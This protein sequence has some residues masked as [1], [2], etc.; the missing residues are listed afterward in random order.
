[1]KKSGWEILQGKENEV[2]QYARGY[3]DYISLNKT[4]R[5]VVQYVRENIKGNKD[6][7]ELENHGKSVALFKEGKRDIKDGLR[8]VAAHIDAPRI[9]M[10]P[11]A[12]FEDRESKTALF[13]T[14]YYGGIKKYQWV[15]RPLAIVGLVVKEDGTHIDVS[16]G[17]SE[18]DPVFTFADLLP[19]LS[20]KVQYDKKLYD[21]I[22]AEKLDL[23]VGSYHIKADDNNKE[24]VKAHIIELLKK[25]YSIEEEDFVSA[26]LEIVPAGRAREVG[27]DRSMIGAYGH[28]DRICGYTGFTAF[29]D[30]AN[31]TWPILLLL[32]DKEEIGSNGNTGARSKFVEYAVLQILEKKGLNTDALS[33]RRILYNSE[34]MSADVSAGVNPGWKEVHELKNAALMGY[35]I[36]V[37]KYT[38]HGGKYGAND[39]HAEYVAKIRKILNERNVPWQPA[40]LGKVDEGGGGTVA[41]YIAETG[42]NTIDAGPAL[43][44]MHSPFE[45]VSKVDLYSSYLAYRAFFEEE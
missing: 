4:E 11:V 3:I 28:D 35:G 39:A 26:E 42:I 20:R 22:P 37:S 6:V 27:L 8:I 13:E 44:S 10:K 32:F 12:I 36:A 24:P 2:E 31:N 30:A 21:A 18:N 40:E 43:L 41:T 7:F 19:H 14:H 15:S 16:I 38:G 1:M 23:L 33:L 34:A 17:E 5:K 25:K 45:I 9:D 29:L